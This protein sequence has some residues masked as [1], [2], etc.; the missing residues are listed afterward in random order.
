M[1]RNKLNHRSLLVEIMR[2]HSLVLIALLLA[3]NTI[4]L[5]AIAAPDNSSGQPEEPKI[6][7]SGFRPEVNGFS[8]PNYGD[9]PSIVDLTPVEMQRM[10]GD[11]VCAGNADG[12]CV[13]TFPAKRWM[14][15]AL[16]A[17]EYGHCEGIAVLSN[18]LYYDLVS[19]S[20]FGGNSSFELSLQNES[21]QREIGYWWVTQVTN[22][23]GSNKVN[24]SPNSVLDTLEKAFGEGQRA[25][26]WWV[27]GLYQ[28]DGSGGHAITPFAIE[29]LGNGTSRILVYDN[30]WPKENRSVEVDRNSNTWQYIA[31]VNPDEPSEVYAGNASTKSLEIV[32]ISPRLGL[33]ECDFCSEENASGLNNT[34]GSLNDQKHIQIWQ[35]GRANTLITDEQG[36]RVGALESG[37]HVNEIPGAEIRNMRFG[38]NREH[39]PVIFVPM[40]PGMAPNITATISGLNDSEENKTDIE[41]KA[42]ITIVA[43]GL[44]VASSIPDL[45]YG[46][47]QSIDLV[48]TGDG[49]SVSINCSQKLSSIISIDTNLQQITI[50]GV[51]TELGGNI[52]ISMDPALG[53]FLM[54]TMGNNNLSAIQIQLTSIDQKSGKS[55]SFTSGNLSLQPNDALSLNSADL[56]DEDHNPSL[57]I[58]HESGAV[59]ELNLVDT[60]SEKL[61]ISSNLTL[62]KLPSSPYLD[63]ADAV[64]SDSSNM[65]LPG[66][67]FP[68]RAPSRR[69]G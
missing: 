31:S 4:L 34:R 30:N 46:Q 23:G 59:E 56:R 41:T 15:E 9:D 39:P 17:M 54:R 26:E 50:S 24:E 55:F 20:R 27:M 48:P 10:F 42:H 63:S 12:K 8:F 2:W 53:S 69:Q 64:L 67:N 36:R 37:E 45:G 68:N 44:A 35:E 29:D 21:L 33:Q 65:K 5:C 3:P 60:S 19:P 25:N 47:R 49:Y 18:L 32:S 57:S 52:N 6:N 28:P 61:P 16:T 13:L 11:G 66:S 43:P 51:N 7:D 22:P 40:P 1:L 14:D 62:V 38:F 58:A